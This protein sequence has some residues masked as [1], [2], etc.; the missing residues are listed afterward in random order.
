LTVSKNINESSSNESKI[1][2]PYM[3]PKGFN[4]Q[5]YK[6][7]KKSDV[8]SIGVLMWQILSGYQPIYDEDADYNDILKERK[9]KIIYGTPDGYSKLCAGKLFL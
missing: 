4:D 8:Y 1:F 6:L 7:N 2:G 9:R 5:N 3:D